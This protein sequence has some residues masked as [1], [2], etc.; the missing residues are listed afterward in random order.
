MQA[1]HNYQNQ[2]IPIADSISMA[3]KLLDSL[4]NGAVI[5]D[6]LGINENEKEAAYSLG[7]FHYRNGKYAD[8]LAYFGFLIFYDHFDVRGYKAV[9]SCMQLMGMVHDAQ[10]F[11]GIAAVMDPE[12][13]MSA[14]Q[15]AE[16]LIK[17]DRK[18]DALTLLESIKKEFGN[19]DKYSSVNKKVNGLLCLL[20][21][22]NTN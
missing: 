8:A 16:C 19:L 14:V 21:K 22:E 18:S 11:L 3:G 17:T 6:A 5:G 20:K 7:L 2:E 15:I 10:V 4:M 9:G 1:N 12:D 13:P